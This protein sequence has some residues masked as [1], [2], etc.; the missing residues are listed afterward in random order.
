MY[1]ELKAFDSPKK[2][3]TRL[4]FDCNPPF[5]ND[6]SSVLD[7]TEFDARRIRSLLLHVANEL[8]PRIVAKNYLHALEEKTIK[9]I[10]QQVQDLCDYYKENGKDCDEQTVAKHIDK[11]NQLIDSGKV[12]PVRTTTRFIF[13][14]A[15]VAFKQDL[16]T[17]VNGDIPPPIRPRP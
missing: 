9:A 13:E 15:T 1:F 2:E 11:I 8:I 4:Q 5:I 6:G 10:P 3:I 7:N 17:S 12:K 16:R 14:N